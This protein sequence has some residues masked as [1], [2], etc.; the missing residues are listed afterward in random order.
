MYI[1]IPAWI[2][3]IPWTLFGEETWKSSKTRLEGW[4]AG[5]K[6]VSPP[7][8][9]SN[10]LLDTDPVAWCWKATAD[11]LWPL[12]WLLLMWAVASPRTKMPQPLLESSRLFDRPQIVKTSHRSGEVH[13]MTPLK[14]SSFA[15]S[16]ILSL[17]VYVLLSISKFNSTGPRQKRGC[18]RV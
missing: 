14:S 6:P 16:I 15:L 2:I 3:F 1:Y 12:N 13:S 10:R 9:P 7:K 5:Q 18:C 17:F 4:F 8:Q 11:I